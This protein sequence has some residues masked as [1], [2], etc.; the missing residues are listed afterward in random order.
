MLR[1]T[2]LEAGYAAG[3]VI[4]GVSLQ[5]AAGETAC[6]VGSSGSGK[7]TMLL[8]LAGL[9][10]GA[11]GQVTLDGAP[12]SAGDRRVG[13]IL[14][15]YGLFPWMTVR[16]NVGIGLR[17]RG[18]G[19]GE[20]RRLARE[21]LESM[22]LAACAARWPRELS[23]G[24]RQ[25][26]A[27]ARCMVLEPELLLMDEPFSSI[28]A[29]AREEMQETLQK[30]LARRRL[31]CVLVTHSVEE[32]VFLGSAIHV[33]SG[34]PAGI[35]E[36]LGNTCPTDRDRTSAG[37][38]ALCSRVRGALAPGKPARSADGRTA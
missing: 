9:L 13:V 4:R 27:I 5:V 29:L 36:S 2:E 12:V 23:G 11:R 20:R 19:E 38:Q 31:A 21:Q 8:A 34:S 22:G 26:V 1:V 6:I 33:L 18:V 35:S 3:P 7:T 30:L 24:Q 17:I 37:F 25:R 32:A 15:D 10:S 14:Q 16:E 28:D